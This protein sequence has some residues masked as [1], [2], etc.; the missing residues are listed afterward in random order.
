MGF[1]RGCGTDVACPA[2]EC[3][4]TARPKQEGDGRNHG[5]SN[6]DSRLRCSSS[7]LLPHRGGGAH[8]G[9]PSRPRQYQHHGSGTSFEFCDGVVDWYWAERAVAPRIWARHPDRS[10]EGSSARMRMEYFNPRTSNG[11]EKR[12]HGPARAGM[13]RTTTESTSTPGGAVHRPGQGGRCRRR[14]R[15]AGRLL[16]LDHPQADPRQRKVFGDA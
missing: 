14:P 16:Q 4:G 10:A 11:T 5:S 3:R 7:S 9:T 8:A 13:N 12:W 1:A 15:A 2:A 6:A